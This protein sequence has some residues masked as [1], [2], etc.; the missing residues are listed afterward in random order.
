MLLKTSSRAEV[1]LWVDLLA[2]LSR[3]VAVFICVKCCC[4]GF[5]NNLALVQLPFTK[6]LLVHLYEYFA[7]VETL[8]V[9]ANLTDLI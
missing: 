5:S 1:A 9:C 4:C 2:K 8:P 6:S 3:S 7:V